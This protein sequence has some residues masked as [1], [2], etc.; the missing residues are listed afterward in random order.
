LWKS[1]DG[2]RTRQLFYRRATLRVSDHKPVYSGF[3]CDIRTVVA[4]KQRQVYQEIMRMI[5]KWEN[6]TIPKVEID[7]LLVEVGEVQYMVKQ[8]RKLQIRNTGN[9]IA[10]FRFVPKLEEATLC[11]RWVSVF[12]TYGMLIPGET[13]EITVAVF[14]DNATAH[15]LNSGAESL[16]DIVILRLE[17]GRDFYITLSA[18]YARSCYGCSLQELVCSPEPMRYK[19]A[20]PP[21]EPLAGQPTLSVPK[22]LWRMIDFLY[23]R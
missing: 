4:E 3:E 18:T 9:V 16:D 11:K 7:G 21:T 6:E 15:A 1:R 13:A 14:I 22:E 17:N 19:P 20:G 8:E 12:P 2:E 10:H 23:K 5:D